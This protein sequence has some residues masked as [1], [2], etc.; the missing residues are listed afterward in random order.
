MVKSCKRMETKQVLSTAPTWA[1]FAAR[2]TDGSWFYYERE[3]V[4][5]PEGDMWMPSISMTRCE[6][7]KV[8]KKYKIN[9]AE[10]VSITR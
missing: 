3:P 5:S 8:V 10:L 6:P 2:D 4:M 7:A 1:K 9:V